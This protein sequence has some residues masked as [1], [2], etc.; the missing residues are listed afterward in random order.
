MQWRE[1]LADNN[2]IWLSDKYYKL[3]DFTEDEKETLLYEISPMPAIKN[4]RKNQE[5]RRKYKGKIKKAIIA[6]RRKGNA[7]AVIF[8]ENIISFTDDKFISYSKLE[9][10][11]KLEMTRKKQRLKMLETYLEAHNLLCEQPPHSNAVYVQ[12]GLFKFPVRW[13]IDTSIVPVRAYIDVVKS[14]LEKHFSDY[15]IESI[16]CHHDE[17][18]LD[19]DIGAHSHYF[20]SG[21]SISTGLY[22][23]HKTQIKVVNEFIKEKGEPLDQLP[24]D[25]KLNWQQSQVY[26]EYFQKMFYEH[27]NTQLLNPLGLKAEIADETERKSEERKRMNRESKLPK[28]MRS[29]NMATRSLE[30]AE[31]RLETLQ[32]QVLEETEQLSAIDNNISSQRDTLSLKVEQLKEAKVLL[33][34]FTLQ[35]T[36]KNEEVKQYESRLTNMGQKVQQMDGQLSNAIADICKKIYLS[37][38]TRNRGLDKQAATYIEEVLKSYANLE[39]SSLNDVCLA[40]ANILNDELLISGMQTIDSSSLNCNDNDIAY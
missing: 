23:L 12:E 15:P 1:E 7:E 36:I 25:Q 13:G 32:Q 4:R 2:L 38:A 40:A 37:I 30:L 19:E 21:K 11:E 16:I 26:G 3:N 33:D 24:S 39:Q 27:V 10:F 28:A 9:V 8:L 35:A 18:E 29:H 22:D 20:L 14:F 17:R 5:N 34:H 31:K 6:E